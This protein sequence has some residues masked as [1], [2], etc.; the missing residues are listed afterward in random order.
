MAELEQLVRQMQ[1]EGLLDDQFQQLLALQDESNPDFVAEV[2]QLY[3]EDSVGKIDKVYQ[4]LSQPLP[5]YEE[6]DQ[7]VH[8]LKGS[9]ASLGA[10]HIAQLCIKLREGCQQRNAAA[11]QQLVQQVKEAFQQLRAKL[12]LFLQVEQQWKSAME[13]GG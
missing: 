1:A 10:T 11:C 12:E 9:S 7:I 4:L 6:L 13:T 5:D 2:V 3:F 8:Q